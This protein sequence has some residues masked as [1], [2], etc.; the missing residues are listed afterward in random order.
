MEKNHKTPRI[1]WNAIRIWCFLTGVLETGF[2]LLGNTATR[3]S[4]TGNV[5]S[6]RWYHEGDEIS[7][8]ERYF[9]RSPVGNFS[10]EMTQERG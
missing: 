9:I 1:Y 2:I 8:E 3:F 6:N 5:N 7:K 10:W 4:K